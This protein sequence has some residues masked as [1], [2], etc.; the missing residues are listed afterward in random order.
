MFAGG[1]ADGN[2]LCVEVEFLAVAAHPTYAAS[3]IPHHQRVGRHVLRYHRACTDEAVRAQTVSADDGGI[4]T[5]RR[6]ALEDGL[7]ILCLAT[8]RRAGL[9]TISAKGGTSFVTT[10]PAPMRQ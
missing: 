1:G 10:E 4:G 2:A 5:H 3:R 8:D 6:A 7:A 9:P